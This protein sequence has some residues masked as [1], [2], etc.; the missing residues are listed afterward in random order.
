MATEGQTIRGLRP[1]VRDVRSG[2]DVEGAEDRRRLGGTKNEGN[3]LLPSSAGRA[4]GQKGPTEEQLLSL[5]VDCAQ[6][7][8]FSRHPPPGLPWFRSGLL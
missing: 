8:S 6:F 2:A 3:R 4:W 1:G 5:A 7:L